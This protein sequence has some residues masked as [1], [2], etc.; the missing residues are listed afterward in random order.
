MKSL[1][2]FRLLILVPRNSFLQQHS[3][4]EY[5]NKTRHGLSSLLKM[6]STMPNMAA[7]SLLIA[8]FDKDPRIKKR[9]KCF[10]LKCRWLSEYKCNV[11]VC[12]RA[13]VCVCVRVCVL[14]TWEEPDRVWS[15]RVTFRRK[16]YLS[17]RR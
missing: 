5:L 9:L 12:V 10:D 14:H 1:F 3:G 8:N 17:T 13:C 2:D 11:C 4:P 16:F 15:H 7:I 6:K